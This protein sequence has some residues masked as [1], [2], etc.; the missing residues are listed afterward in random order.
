[1]TL[2]PP[3]LEL[4]F[5]VGPL[6]APEQA[7]RAAE[8][9]TGLGARFVG[10]VD[11]VEAGTPASMHREELGSLRTLR[12]G[13]ALRRLYL[14]NAIGISSKTELI[15]VSGGVVVVRTEGEEF[16]GPNRT[17][18]A[19]LFELGSKA[20]A[21]FKALAVSIEC[22][23]GA[24]CGEYSLEE[25]GELKRD[26]RSLAFRDFFVSGAMLGGV[27]E[28]VRE[29]AGIGVFTE[30]L[31]DRGLYVSMSPE[32]NPEHRALDPIE[33][34]DRSVRIAGVLAAHFGSWPRAPE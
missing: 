9:L 33:A 22:Y 32:F 23:Y 18:E 5:F 30:E 20:Y 28:A 3:Y 7:V 14:E 13:V 17:Q 26:P 1:M 15:E 19:R 29:A 10:R 24:L 31:G 8:T 21:R 25:P 11:V 12:D 34:Q 6:G 4:A 27:P 2:D 16:C